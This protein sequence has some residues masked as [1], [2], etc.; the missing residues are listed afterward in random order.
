MAS[1]TNRAN[2]ITFCIGSVK[3][4]SHVVHPTGT[5]KRYDA[6]RED[7]VDPNNISTPQREDYITEEN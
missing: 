1:S 7:T 5:K 4:A 2:R 6:V 3:T